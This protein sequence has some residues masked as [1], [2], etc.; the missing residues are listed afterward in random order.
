MLQWMSLLCEAAGSQVISASVPRTALETFS[1]E[2]QLW[3]VSTS[4]GSRRGP[5]QEGLL[6]RPGKTGRRDHGAVAPTEG[7][8]SP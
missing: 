4:S 7:S 5:V 6:L 1:Q 2:G 3:C 8:G